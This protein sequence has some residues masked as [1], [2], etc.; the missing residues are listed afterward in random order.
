M[1]LFLLH[2]ATAVKNTVENTC[3]QKDIIATGMDL[4]MGYRFQISKNI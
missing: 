4:K 3:C 2:V 1:C